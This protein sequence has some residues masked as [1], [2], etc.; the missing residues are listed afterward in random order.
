MQLPVGGN[1]SCLPEKGVTTDLAIPW[2]DTAGVT[3]ICHNEL[4]ISD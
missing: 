2:D 3:S 4:P 1:P